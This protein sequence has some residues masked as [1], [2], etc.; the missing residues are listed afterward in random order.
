MENRKETTQKMESV[1][2]K[3]I[4]RSFLTNAEKWPPECVGMFYQPHRPEKTFTKVQNKK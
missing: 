2:K 1:A 3:L 4:R